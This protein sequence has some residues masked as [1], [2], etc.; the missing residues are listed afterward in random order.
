M[1]SI[2]HTVHH[3]L[4]LLRSHL[5]SLLPELLSDIGNRHGRAED[6]RAAGEGDQAGAGGDEWEEVDDGEADGEGFVGID[7]TRTPGFES[8][9]APS[10]ELLPGT[11]VRWMYVVE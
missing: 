7:G 8:A 3:Y 11:A 6:V 2:C 10:G 4:D 9:F 5:R 1:G